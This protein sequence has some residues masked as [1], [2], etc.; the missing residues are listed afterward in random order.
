MRANVSDFA[1]YG[2]VNLPVARLEF[3]ARLVR[4]KDLTSA[5]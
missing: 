3:A 5:F 4:S 1:A 2:A